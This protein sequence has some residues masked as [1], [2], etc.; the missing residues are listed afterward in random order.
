MYFS[1]EVAS[2]VEEKMLTVSKQGIVH[3]E[4]CKHL[5][6]AG[7]PTYCPRFPLIDET[8]SQLAPVS[9]SSTEFVGSMLLSLPTRSLFSKIPPR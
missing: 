3:H 6:P 2:D 4:P 5:D 8:P 7:T 1:Y 9:Y